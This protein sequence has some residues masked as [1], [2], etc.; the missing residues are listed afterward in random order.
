M[1]SRHVVTS[2][3]LLSFKFPLPQY[4]NKYR[5]Y[6]GC[7]NTASYGKWDLLIRP[8]SYANTE[9]IQSL[10]WTETEQRVFNALKKTHESSSAIIK[11]FNLFMD[12]SKGTA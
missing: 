5:N 10:E 11:P 2:V 12:G 4:K 7:L 1:I 8:S 6:L 9:V 3:F